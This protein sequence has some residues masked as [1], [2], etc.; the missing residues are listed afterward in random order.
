[1]D[2]R[3]FIFFLATM[4]FASIKAQNFSKYQV[5]GN[6]I[7]LKS[8]S[9]SSLKSSM[10]GKNNLW[11]NNI[12]VQIVLPT[13]NHVNAEE[14]SNLIYNKSHTSV[15]KYWL[16]LV[17]QGRVAA[18]IFCDTDEEILIFIKNKKGSIGLIEKTLTVPENLKITI[19]Q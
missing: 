17:F 13:S 15:R 14:I 11:N 5:I 7:G 18:P 2:F 19:Y 12:Q 8:M 4:T 3:T 10:K 1:M 9:E 16:S 6:N